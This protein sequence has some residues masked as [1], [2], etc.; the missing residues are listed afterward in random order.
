MT[1]IEPPKEAEK[2]D[3]TKLLDK[4]VPKMVIQF[5]IFKNRTRVSRSF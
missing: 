3:K 1:S 5:K 2:G 4:L